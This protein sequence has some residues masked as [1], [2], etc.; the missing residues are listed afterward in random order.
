MAMTFGALPPEI[1]SGRMYS[2]PGPE[3]MMAATAAWE[4]LAARLQHIAADYRTVGS[5]LAGGWQG[6]EATAMSQALATH[7]TWLNTA[8]VQA[9]HAAAQ[10][11][12]AANAYAAAVAAMV[13]PP[14]IDANRAL[15]ISLA[16]TNCLGQ[17]SPAIAGAD[18]DYEG[19]WAQDADA[20]DAYASASAAVSR[21]TPFTSPPTSAGHHRGAVVAQQS[22]SWALATAPEVIS[23][24][25]Q[26]MSA[27][28]GVLQ[29]LSSSPLTTFD[30][31]P[32]SVTR[33]LS[34]LSALSA[35]L[36][37]AIYR[38]NSLN[39][40]AALR[41]LLPNPGGGRGAAFTAGCGRA[42]SIGTLTVP[43]AWAIATRSAVTVERQCDWA[44]DLI[45]LVEVG[46]PPMWPPVR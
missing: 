41:S 25:H 45:R 24:G 39:R 36:D 8:T 26:V 11:R 6:P 19:M 38:L 17:T 43:R 34:K 32:A 3:S 12:A 23:T 1:N 31:F 10:A 35:R 33:S 13:P 14:V 30:A 27:I 21:L 46:E 9:K 28:P 2:G 42:T 22:P 18:A 16:S 7:I 37:F 44:R 4:A 5:R 20:M 40:A 29:A 15:R